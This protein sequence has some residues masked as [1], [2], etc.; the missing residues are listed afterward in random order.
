MA[1]NSAVA[2]T[3]ST[4]QQVRSGRWLRLFPLVTLAVF[5]LPVGAG[6]VGAVLPAFNYLP[7]LGGETL[8]L[9]AWRRLLAYPGLWDAVLFSLYTGIGASL[10]SFLIVCLF[11]A[12]C[13]QTRLFDRM[14][15]VLGP[16]LAVPHSAIAI[17]FLF[18]FAP[19]G[20]IIRLISPWATGWDRPPDLPLAPDAYGISLIAA[21]VLKETPYLLLMMIGALHQAPTHRTLT[22][23]RS[24]GYDRVTAW[25]KT[26][27]P[28]IYGPMRLPLFA[29]LVF[30]LS[31]VDVALILTP[32]SR[33]TLGVLVLRWFND[34]DLDFQFL[35]G[36]GACLQVMMALA[37]LLVWL[38]LERLIARLGLGW[39]RQGGRGRFEAPLRRLGSG[40]IMLVLIAGITSLLMLALWSLAWRWRYPSALPDQWGLTMWMRHGEMLTGPMVT[41]VLLGASA[42]GLALILTL[43]CLET[44]QRHGLHPG[45]RALWLL[46]TPLLIP[47]A[48]FL[49]GAQALLGWARID[50]TFPALIWGHLLFVLPYVFLSLAEPYR[51]LDDR[52]ARTAACLGASSARVFWRVKLPILLRPI[53]VAA[54]I[55][56]AVSVGE[57]LPTIFIGAGRYATLTTEAV[58]LASGGD[59]RLVGLFAFLQ[60]TLPLAGFL[61]AVGLPG[62]IYRNRR[63]MRGG[64]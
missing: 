37:V 62:W 60:A 11:C 35:A 30:S 33:P 1:A 50:G 7:S 49:F 25:F 3:I 52:Y 45:S 19:S 26:L 22:I 59:R 47:Q 9:D 8:S 20:W 16:L 46:Y 44:E 28:L 18:L 23:S 57:Y 40:G 32:S 43:G 5:L 10:L 56:F 64:S 61:V 54:A 14:R 38:M 39:V 53:L 51:R 29:V 55:G 12:C 17:G 2:T 27:L 42:A 4:G 48:A 58:S 13:Y 36:A 21:L 24:L 63:A 31:V 41:T 34:P 15:R 6:L